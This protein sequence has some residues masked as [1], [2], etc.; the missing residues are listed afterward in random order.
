MEKVDDICDG[1][2][3]LESSCDDNM[4]IAMEMMEMVDRLSKM[5]RRDLKDET[6]LIESFDVAESL[7]NAEESVMSLKEENEGLESD[8]EQCKILLERIAEKHKEKSKDLDNKNREE[9]LRTELSIARDQIENLKKTMQIAALEEEEQLLA[10]ETHIT[11]L[12]EEY[13]KK[14]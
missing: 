10:Q 2:S 3:Q 12:I 8:L 13:N 11:S 5:I 1:S 7:A 4:R 9:A 6:A 14:N